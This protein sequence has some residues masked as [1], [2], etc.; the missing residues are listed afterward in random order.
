MSASG[1]PHFRRCMTELRAEQ[2]TVSYR[3]FREPFAVRILARGARGKGRVS[4]TEGKIRNRMQ[5][6]ASGNGRVTTERPVALDQLLSGIGSQ[7]E[8][9]TRPRHIPGNI[10]ATGKEVVIM[11]MDRICLQI[12][13]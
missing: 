7:V 4:E 8:L 10:L 6:Q 11:M 9:Q 12:A 3:G 13:A 5:R 2:L 1:I